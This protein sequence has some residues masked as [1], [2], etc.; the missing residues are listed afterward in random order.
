MLS[1]AGL[2]SFAVVV[3]AFAGCGSTKQAATTAVTSPVLK[4][5]TRTEG[6]HPPIKSV[7]YSIKLASTGGGGAPRSAHV[8][9]SISA[10]TKELCWNFS[11]LKN[12]TAPAE[13]SIVGKSRMGISRTPLGPPQ[14]G[15]YREPG[16]LLGVLE[17]EPKSFYVSIENEKYPSGAVSGPL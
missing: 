2:V 4:R 14:T 7:S 8:Q 12:V 3:L 17:A 1:R 5:A 13:A 10:P 6:T 9:I 15:C 16:T 11:Q